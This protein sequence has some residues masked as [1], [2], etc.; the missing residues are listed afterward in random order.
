ML[1]CFGGSGLKGRI[2]RRGFR[3][4]RG[5]DFWRGRSFESSEFLV[6]E[7]IIWGGRFGVGRIL[8]LLLRSKTAIMRIQVYACR[9]IKLS[10][11]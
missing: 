10:R 5:D 11:V 1:F 3:S 2:F 7:V 9:G 4:I 6:R 8:F